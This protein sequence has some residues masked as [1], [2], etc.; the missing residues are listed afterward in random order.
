MAE[1]T[2]TLT[3]DAARTDAWIASMKTAA[4]TNGD[5]CRDV[6]L[7]LDEGVDLWTI[8]PAALSAG[9]LTLGV[10]SSPRLR[11]LLDKHGVALDG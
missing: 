9:K 7:L 10:S 8:E 5:F 6:E 1:S 4:A 3:L 2:V 11:A